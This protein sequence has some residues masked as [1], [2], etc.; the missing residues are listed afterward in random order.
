MIQYG[1]GSFLVREMIRHHQKQMQQIIFSNSLSRF[2]FVDQ[3]RSAR[4]LKPKVHSENLAS[5]PHIDAE[6]HTCQD[7]E[8]AYGLWFYTWPI[9]CNQDKLLPRQ[10]MMNN[11]SMVSSFPFI[12]PSANVIN[13]I[14]LSR[15]SQRGRKWGKMFEK[16]TLDD[17]PL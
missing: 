11:I 9:N 12:P 6:L 8:S 5:V 2:L 7:F 17:A 3:G 1:K 16:G 4:E 13:S 14:I 15:V 10:C